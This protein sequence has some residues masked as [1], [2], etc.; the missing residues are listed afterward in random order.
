MSESPSSRPSIGPLTAGN[1]VSAG[2]RLY[3][4]RFQPYFGV[5]VQATLWAVLPFLVL[6]PIPLLLIYGEANPIALFLL[7]PIGII[8][9]FYGMAKYTANTALISRLA[10]RELV[11][12][13]ESIQEAR[14]QIA[15]KFWIFFRAYLLMFFISCVGVL[16]FYILI[17]I[18]GGIGAYGVYSFQGN[19]FAIAIIVLVGLIGFAVLMS[20]LIRFFTRLF[21]FEVPLAI[22]ENIN[23]S[24]TIRR[25]WNLTKGYIGRIF[26]IL[27]VAFLV[28]LPLYIVVQIV[29]SLIQATLLRFLETTPTSFGFQLLSFFIGYILGLVSGAVVQPFWQ[30]IKATIY[31]DL[32]SRKEG[33]GLQVRDSSL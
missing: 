30:A 2:F 9:F 27:T 11:N 26:L 20:L 19:I 15:P 13:P 33:M 8:L 29:V 22:E 10:F 21:M 3:R 24:Q 28:T 16:V 17:L 32:R 14:H 12:K 23:A 18:I 4:D 1:V 31:Y 5:A 6:I 7:I 25:S